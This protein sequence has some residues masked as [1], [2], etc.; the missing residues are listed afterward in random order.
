MIAVE[1]MV[2]IPAIFGGLGLIRDGMGM[3]SAWID[4]TLLPS[5]TVPGI[6]LVLLI[7]GGMI[8]AAFATVWDR[9]L[10]APAA[11]VMG[12]V[13][14]QWMAIETLMVG[15]HGGPQLP[16]DAVVVTAAVALLAMGGWCTSVRAHDT[17]SK[18]QR[19]RPAMWAVLAAFYA[20]TL[21]ISW[22]WMLPFV[23]GGDVIH[24]GDGWP[25]HLPALMGP[26]IAAVIVT[27]WTLGK[28]GLRDLGSRMIR[29]RVGVRWWLWGLGSPLAYFAVALA[30]VRLSD[31]H[32]PGVSGLDRYSGVPSIGVIGV[33]GVAIV[34]A[35]GEETGWR[36]FALPHL[37]RRYS[38][39][40]ASLIVV[41]LWA[42]WHAP[43]FATLS[44]YRD[45]GPMQ[46]PG[47]LFGLACGSVVLTW[48]YNRSGA[49]I[50]IVAVW[51]GTFQHG[52]RRHHRDPGHHRS[53]GQ[54]RHHDPGAHPRRPGDP[55]P[56]HRHSHGHRAPRYAGLGARENGYRHQ[57]RVS[58]AYQAVRAHPVV[59]RATVRD[60]RRGSPPGVG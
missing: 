44:T 17:A 26:M 35:L 49:S 29:W 43:Y 25:T 6:L 40:I 50:L 13:L 19:G 42:F 23:V 14:L 12:V 18:A 51:H 15:W 56:A 53:G 41:P 16:L 47:F 28:A 45:F 48:L 8:T 55:R 37:Q 1:L 60:P 39:L 34:G 33:W 58:P 5:W 52:R 11:L 4:H 31:G 3:D 7:G 9:R 21:A 32:W 36:G 46:Y 22:G 10:A 54:H 59:A 2:G 20:L 30:V 24:R 27:A 57:P 38:A